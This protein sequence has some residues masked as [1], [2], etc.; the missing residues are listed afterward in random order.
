GAFLDSTLDRIAESAILVGLS[1]YYMGNLVDL[2]INPERVMRDLQR[3]LEPVTWAADAALAMLALTGS[4]MVS[5]TRA[6]GGGRGLGCEVGW[7]ERPER[8]VL[9][10]VAGLFGLGPVIPAALLL[11]A[12]LSFVTA[13]Q[14]VRHVWKITR[15]AGMDS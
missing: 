11:L 8:M 2:A 12:V 7:F 4:F 5:S 6:R 14:R 15:G 9:L 3:G 13:A 10:I 1:W